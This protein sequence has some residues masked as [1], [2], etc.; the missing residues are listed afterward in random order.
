M[1]QIIVLSHVR[2]EL[3]TPTV[4]VL[5]GGGVFTVQ[6]SIKHFLSTMN[7]VQGSSTF[8]TGNAIRV[9]PLSETG[10]QAERNPQT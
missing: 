9:V 1:R 4:K 7:S 8:R 3:G 6:C 2:V 10:N 5:G